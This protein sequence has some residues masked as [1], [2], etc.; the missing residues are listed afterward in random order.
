[1]AAEKHAVGAITSAVE[2]VLLLGSVKL[3]G[4]TVQLDTRLTS[5]SHWTQS[6]LNPSDN[7]PPSA[8]RRGRDPRP[9]RSH[10]TVFIGPPPLPV[11][12]LHATSRQFM[13]H[14]SPLAAAAVNLFHRSAFTHLEHRSTSQCVQSSISL[15]KTTGCSASEDVSRNTADVHS[16]AQ[17][18][19]CPDKSS[20]NAP[21]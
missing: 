2:L 11:G 9:R 20:S 8:V 5:V 4:L 17:R 16:K 18:P 13:S 3:H 6:R 10:H 1:M 19:A 21:S 14:S 15:K 7:C 12:I